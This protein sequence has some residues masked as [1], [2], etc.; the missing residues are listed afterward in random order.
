MKDFGDCKAKAL[1]FQDTLK[2]GILQ[3]ITA[4]MD[5]WCCGGENLVLWKLQKLQE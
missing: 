3:L 1:V 2:V 5:T 4:P